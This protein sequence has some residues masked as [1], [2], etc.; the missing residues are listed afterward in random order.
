MGIEQVIGAYL[1]QQFLLTDLNNKSYCWGS[2]STDQDRKRLNRLL[3]RASSVLGCPLD[4]VEWV[5]ER[6]MFANWV[7]QKSK[8]HF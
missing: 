6:R 5:G 7:T 3:S 2:G 1:R 8:K 4:S